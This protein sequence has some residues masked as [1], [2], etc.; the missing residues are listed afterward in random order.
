MRK[1]AVL[2]TLAVTASL[3]AGPG[4]LRFAMPDARV[5]V[6]VNV[7]R[8]KQTPFGR[9]ALAQFS[10]S[11][12]AGFDNFVKA[13]GFDPRT[14][15]DEVLY[16]SPAGPE[17]NRRLIVATGAFD[18]Q[19]I[20]QLAKTAGGQV[21]PFQ[22][23]D[24]ITNEKAAAA[25]PHGLPMSIAFLDT[26]TA[27]AGDS[28]SVRTA[29]SNRGAGPG[30]APSIMQ[31]SRELSAV[32]D[33]WLVSTVP[34]SEL[35][36]GLPGNDISGMLKG[37]A[38]KTISQASGGLIFGDMVKFT[39]ELV[40]GSAEDASA[41]AGVLQFLAGVVQAGGRQV[42]LDKLDLKADGNVVRVSLAIP[43]QQFESLI[44][45]AGKP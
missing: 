19:R 2:F 33:A 45:Q 25:S 40:A 43:E 23:V 42:P 4:L 35:A 39:G 11:E 16:A 1:I 7:A 9:F 17:A 8:M 38:L 14:N 13:S 41:L 22:G 5:V 12:D 29:I 26:G 6:G 10:S 32:S 18:P 44:R 15:L 3:A 27:I 31:K 36:R 20:L 30:P 34:V 21:V 37:E 28:E 24:I